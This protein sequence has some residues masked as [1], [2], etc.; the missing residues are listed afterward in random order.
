VNQVNRNLLTELREIVG[1]K[2]VSDDMYV[3]WSYSMDSN[4]FDVL[5]PTPPR[6]V[7]R[8]GSVEEV[9][10]I[11]KLANM[12]RT[13]VYV[14]G[15][16]T[17]G[18]G[19]RGDKIVDSILIDVTRMNKIV[20]VDESS[21]TVTVEAG[22]TWGKLNKE[23][24]EKGW[25]LG[26]KGPY[27]GYGST[28]GGSVAVQS[29]G[30]GSPRYGVV[31]ED[32]TN[33]KVVLANGEILETGSAVNPAARKFYR[34]CVG[35]DLAGLFVGSGGC[36]G[37][38]AEVTLRL[39]PQAVSEAFG[40]YGFRDYE[41]CQKCYYRWLKTEE[42]THLAWFAEDGLEVNSPELRKEGYVSM[43]TFVVED[44]TARL[45]EARS[46]LLHRIALD[47]NGES[48]D[49]EKYA[50][51]DWDYKFE[52]LPRWAAKIGQ[53]Q[54]NCH[55]IPAGDT[56]ADLKSILVFLS[57]HEAEFKRHKI[58]HSTVSI[59]HKN[60]GHVSTSLY[61]DQNSPEAT[62][63]VR[64]L[65]DKYAELAIAKNGGCNYWL[66]KIW[67]PYTILR[68]PVYRNLLISLKKA[69]DPNNIMN[70]GGL[71]LPAGF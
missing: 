51:G 35:P 37:V 5:N 59:A 6:I 57:Q 22:A 58:T 9:S 12:S 62:E 56:L 47:E 25:R 14:R 45:V 29:N 30:Y 15:G 1:P 71:T 17:D 54:W 32:L 63:L 66:G 41:S 49:A 50:K 21:Q 7:A 8:P 65:C 24:E 43:L 27:S 19:S 11:L 67:Y 3:R 26:F 39:Y 53:W 31:A 68:N 44:Q 34:Y 61:Y 69:L 42:A 23:V 52:L 38:I 60:A 10:R 2:Y 13:P 18:G 4:I 36:F 55:M 16:G 28:V 33:L 46:E 40:A 20:Q 48:L 70:P 64:K